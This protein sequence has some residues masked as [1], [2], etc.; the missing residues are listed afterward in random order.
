MRAIHLQ[1]NG[2]LVANNNEVY[3]FGTG[4]FS[5]EAWVYSSTCGPVISRKSTAG[6]V[7][8]GGFVWMITIDDG[9]GYASV[10]SNP[11]NVLDG[12]WHHVA[13]VCEQTSV[14]D[15]EQVASDRKLGDKL[16]SLDVNNSMPLYIGSIDQEQQPLRYFTGLMTEIRIWKGARE[17]KTIKA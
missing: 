11:T 13:V 7:G 3:N 16:P 9:T 2:Y 8:N 5:M 4:N 6:G 10:T 1:N 12:I 14:V 17:E 15:G